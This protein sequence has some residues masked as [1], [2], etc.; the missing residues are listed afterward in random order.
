ML[1]IEGSEV[2]MPSSISSAV[3]GHLIDRER[4]EAIHQP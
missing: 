3:V 4:V 2:I 1:I